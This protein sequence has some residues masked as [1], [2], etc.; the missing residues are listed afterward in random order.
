[1]YAARY[2][3]F[4]H[5]RATLDEIEESAHLRLCG[6]CAQCTARCSNDVPIAANIRDLKAMYL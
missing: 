4:S 1:M 6:L 5:A 3:N 2:G